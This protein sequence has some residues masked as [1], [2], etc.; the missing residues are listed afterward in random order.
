MEEVANHYW[1]RAENV[2]RITTH[3][4]YGKKPQEI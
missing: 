3:S 1:V 2:R 4:F